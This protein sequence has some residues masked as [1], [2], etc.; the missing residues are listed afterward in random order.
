MTLYD[1]I[2]MCECSMTPQYASYEKHCEALKIVLL[3]MTIPEERDN[4]VCAA[5]M[6]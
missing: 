4:R 1:I 3:C 6:F 2:C 5:H